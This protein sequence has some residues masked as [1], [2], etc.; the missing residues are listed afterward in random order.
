MSAA[1]WEVLAAALAIE[2]RKVTSTANV[3]AVFA[4]E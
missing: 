3:Y 4:I 1:P 2:P